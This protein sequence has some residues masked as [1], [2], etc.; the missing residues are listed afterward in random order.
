MSLK[1]PFVSVNGV[2]DAAISPLDRGF[3]YGDGIFETCRYHAGEIP[4]WFFHRDRLVSSAQ[5]LQIPLNESVLMTRLT[6]V[7]NLLHSAAIMA[8]VVKIQV[9]RGAGGRGY[10]IPLDLEP[11]YCISVFPAEP[12]HSSN[13]LNGVD[14]RICEQRLSTNKSLAGMKHLNRLE[15]ILARA[16]WQDEYAEGLVMDDSGNLIEATVSNLFAVKNK[17][18][19]TPDL[20]FC[21]VAGIMRRTILENLA[22]Q[23][24]L[25]VEVGAMSLDFVCSADELFLCNSVYGIWPVNR[26]VDQRTAPA[27]VANFAQHSLTRKLQNS[28]EQFFLRVD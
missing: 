21:G 14:V 15:Q 18:L 4:L 27:I 2:L 6:S 7:L 12:L 5:R 9:T 20:T 10:R 24:A 3:A 16:E 23:L 17:Q 8:A 19:Y 13:Y 26:L 28:V 25:N 11:T 22:P 1:L